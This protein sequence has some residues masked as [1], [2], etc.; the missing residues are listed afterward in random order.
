M[1]TG[2]EKPKYTHYSLSQAQKRERISCLYSSDR[3]QSSSFPTN[4]VQCLQLDHVISKHRYR[5][6]YVNN[7]LARAKYLYSQN[8]FGHTGCVN[9]VNFSNSGEEL[10]VSGTERY[11]YVSPA[12]QNTHTHT[13]THTIGGDD[14]KVQLW[15]VSE[16]M[17][18]KYQS[19]PMETPHCSNIFTATFSC[20]NAYIYSGGTC[21]TWLLCT[22]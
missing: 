12:L 2:E 8:V 16:I 6:Y 11:N 17:R 5:Q 15:R 4:I 3:A 1:A 13:H 9:A 18:G 19:V 21:L 7:G 22:L 10:L 14:E 20:D